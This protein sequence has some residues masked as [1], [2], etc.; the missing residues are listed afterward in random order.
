MDDVLGI[1]VV[2]AGSGR[3]IMILVLGTSSLLPKANGTTHP[4][5]SPRWKATP[6]AFCRERSRQLSHLG[7]GQMRGLATASAHCAVIDISVDHERRYIFR[8]TI[9]RKKGRDLDEEGIYKERGIGCNDGCRLWLD[10]VT[11]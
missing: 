4:D 11:C 2:V 10:T 6:G 8:Q 9:C 7:I 5:V 3:S 1:A